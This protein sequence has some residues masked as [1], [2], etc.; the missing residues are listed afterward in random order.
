MSE[1]LKSR[2]KHELQRV[3]QELNET[4]ENS[5]VGDRNDFHPFISRSFLEQTF[6]GHSVRRAVQFYL[7]SKNTH[8]PEHGRKIGGQRYQESQKNDANGRVCQP[9]T[10]RLSNMEETS[11]AS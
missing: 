9:F 5:Q 1:Q 7:K 2:L 4:L 8:L 6:S 3:K 11:N 10:I